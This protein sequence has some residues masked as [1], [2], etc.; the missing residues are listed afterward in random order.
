MST[1]SNEG[2]GPSRC[3]IATPIGPVPCKIGSQPW[4]VVFHRRQK[5]IAIGDKV[6]VR[7]SGSGSKWFRVVMDNLEPLR[8]SR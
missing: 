4:V 2:L 5:T 7:K 3:S 6:L 8:A 1:D